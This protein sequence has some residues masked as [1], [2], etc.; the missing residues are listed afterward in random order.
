MEIRVRVY[1]HLGNLRAHNRSVLHTQLPHAAICLMQVSLVRFNCCCRL[2][3]FL[4][5]GHSRL[6]RGHCL[7]L[8]GAKLVQYRFQTCTITVFILYD[9]ARVLLISTTRMTLNYQNPCDVARGI[10]SV[11]SQQRVTSVSKYCVSN[12]SFL[13][14]CA[15]LMLIGSKF[16]RLDNNKQI[17]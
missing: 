3:D 11:L 8:Q 1:K 17:G 4:S 9:V 13:F 16:A 7:G 6:V 12:K 10:A 5:F 2:V 15:V 14:D